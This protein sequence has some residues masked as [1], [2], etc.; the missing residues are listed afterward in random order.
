VLALWFVPFIAKCTKTERDQMLVLMALTSA[1]VVFWTLYEQSYGTWNAFS[2]RAMNRV[3]LGIDWTASQLT[4]LGSLFI[5]A[6]SPAF[7]WAWP[8]LS[9]RGRN[10]STPAKF[11]YALVLAGIA[12]GVLGWGAGS[13]GADGLASVWWLVAAYFVLTLGEMML[14]PIGLSAV[15]TLSVPRVVSL[16]MGTWF[17]ASAFGEI[18][19]GRLGTLA[20]MEPGTTIPVALATF[21]GLFRLLAGVGVV[22]GLAFFTIAPALRRRMHGA[23]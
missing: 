21:A 9:A 10:P 20:A 22:T 17:L 2:D 8:R 1:S 19:A 11:A 5:F 4:S 15:T 3:A 16:M 23:H 14:S 18:L 12:T 13:P 7:A 6:V